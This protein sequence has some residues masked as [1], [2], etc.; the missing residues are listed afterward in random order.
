[1]RPLVRSDSHHA[2][3]LDPDSLCKQGNL[4]PELFKAPPPVQ[5]AAH[6]ANEMMRSVAE[7]TRTGQPRSSG[8]LNGSAR[9][10]M[11]LPD[12]AGGRHN[13]LRGKAL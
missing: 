9:L 1:M 13:R 6:W 3:I 8:I 7:L 11:L 12:V 5:A 4:S 10:V 2:S